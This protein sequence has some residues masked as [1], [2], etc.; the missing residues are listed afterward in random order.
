MIARV[1]AA[2]LEGLNAREVTVEVDLA[3]GML[4]FNLVG[5]PDTAIKEAKE[6]VHSAIRNSDLEYPYGH[7]TINLAPAEV[8]KSGTWY[9]LPMALGMLAASAQI[10]QSALD[11]VVAVGELSLDGSVRA[12]PGVL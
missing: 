4:D 2:A 5:L 1:Y 10:P 9:D 3:M 11:G 12:V 8:R 6:R 7:I